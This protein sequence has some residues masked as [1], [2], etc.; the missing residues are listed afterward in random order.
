MM[1][2]R[3][4]VAYVVI[5]LI[6]G[7]A[8]ALAVAVAS[9][10]SDASSASVSAHAEAS[11]ASLYSDATGDA[12]AAADP[13]KEQPLLDKFTSKDPF[14]PLPTPGATGTA[15]PTASPSPTS[16]SEPSTNMSAKIKIDGT[17][18]NVMAGDKVPGGA[19]E[20]TVTEVSSSDVT[21]KVIDGTLENGDKS[22]TV[23]LGEAVR[24][25]LES[26]PSYD[27]SVISIGESGGGGGGTN[28]GTSVT[29]SIS[30]LSVTS[31]NGT[32]L[33]TLK[34]DGK[35]Y[36]DLKQGDVISTSFGQIEI[37]SINVNGQTVTIMHGDQTFTLHAGQVV[38][39]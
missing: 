21:F 12:L 38:V 23:N 3:R 30:V 20:F 14:I 29:H 18:Y 39:K 26:G 31:H 1:Q 34:V 13:A 7:A 32:A 2:N 36:S 4:L 6:V 35:T 10:H 11:A 37:V 28:G 33:V 25:T 27:I 9:S 5:A 16:T 8:L 24:V 22:F 15:N 19:A 17:T